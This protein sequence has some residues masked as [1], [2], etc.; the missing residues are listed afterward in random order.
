MKAYANVLEDWDDKVGE[1]W[2]EPESEFLN[3]FSWIS[4]DDWYI[5]QEGYLE[6]ILSIGFS[7][8]QQFMSKFHKVM[9][10]YWKNKQFDCKILVHERIKNPIDSL[11]DTLTLFNWQEQLFENTIPKNTNLGL[12]LLDSQGTKDLLTPN[13]KKMVTNIENIVPKV[14]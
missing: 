6:D 12:L 5:N 8:A 14:I 2:D 4:E 11:N 1:N 3:P 7:K 13:P 10:I 9:E